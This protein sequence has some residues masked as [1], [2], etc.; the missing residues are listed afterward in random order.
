[1]STHSSDYE[2][3]AWNDENPLT[4]TTSSAPTAHSKGVIGLDSN[5][6][7]GFYM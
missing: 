7:S 3:I 1:M 2:L 6:N 4:G 5:S